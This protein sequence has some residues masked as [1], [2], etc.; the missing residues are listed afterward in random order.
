M[1][2]K[3]RFFWDLRGYFVLRGVVSAEELKETMMR[4]PMLRCPG[5]SI[6]NYDLF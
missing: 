1:D 4:K 5:W 3:E 2:A 6:T